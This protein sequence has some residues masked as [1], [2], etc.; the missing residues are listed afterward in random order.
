[1]IELC[2]NLPVI[3]L[4][5]QCR[6][7]YDISSSDIFSN[8]SLL[9]VSGYPHGVVTPAEIFSASSKNRGRKKRHF[10]QCRND[11]IFFRLCCTH[12]GGKNLMGCCYTRVETGILCNFLVNIFEY[13]ASMTIKR[14]KTLLVCLPIMAKIF[15]LWTI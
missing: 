12:K 6:A 3:A 14:R 2:H 8:I 5:H 7:Q 11:D 10:W 4:W 9:F 15:L 13:L 1:M